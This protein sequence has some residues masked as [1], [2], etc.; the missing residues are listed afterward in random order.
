[1]ENVV[2]YA[3]SLPHLLLPFLMA[4]DHEAPREIQALLAFLG[5]MVTLAIQ[6]SQVPLALLALLE[7]AHHVQMAVR[8]ILPSMTP[9][10]SSLELEE[11]WVAILDHLVPQ[12]LQAPLALLDILAPL[13]LLDTKVPLVNLVKLVL[14]AL[15]DLLVLLVH[16]ALL[17]RMESQ[18]DLVDLESVDYL[19][20]RV[21]KAQ[22][23]CLDSLG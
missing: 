9:T 19:A 20:L 14:P 1:M 16:L 4:M 13:V 11:E 5:E 3:R 18:G 12:A 17:E 10:M 8:I 2:Q 22:A 23:V 15:Q 7:S 6:G 21:L